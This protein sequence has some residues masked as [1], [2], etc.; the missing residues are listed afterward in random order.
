MCRSLTLTVRYADGSSTTRSRA[1]GEASHH[2]PVLAAA[3]RDLYAG[4]GLQR[5]R[6]TQIAV[7]AE[8]L[9]AADGAHHQLQLGDTDDKAHRLE[10]VTDAAR[11]RCGTHVIK[12]AA[13]AEHHQETGADP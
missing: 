9:A 1:L 6:V 5:A 2:S 4:L 12:P 8:Q 10:V 3:A 7:R 13:L 11:S